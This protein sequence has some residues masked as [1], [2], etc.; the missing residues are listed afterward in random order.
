MDSISVKIVGDEKIA[1]ALERSQ[2][3]MPQLVRKL[4][5][6]SAHMIERSLKLRY[7][8][9][10]L[11]A[12]AG[13]AG[14]EGSVRAFLR[15]VGGQV[16]AGAGTSKVY[17]RIHEFGGVI[18]PKTKKALLFQVGKGQTGHYGRWVLVKSVV[19][20]ARYPAR[21]AYR[22]TEP[23][24]RQLWLKGLKGLAVLKGA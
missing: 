17:A 2:K 20:P 11:Y 4:G 6:A 8:T 5:W 19:M 21:T 9:G 14:L 18:L 12:R 13:S 3:E 23:Q 22:E 1:R 16:R 10:P 24:V 15:M 7:S